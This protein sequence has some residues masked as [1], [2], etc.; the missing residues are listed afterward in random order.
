MDDYIKQL[1]ADNEKLREK[2][3][4]AQYTID[5]QTKELQELKHR[6]RFLIIADDEKFQKKTKELQELQELKVL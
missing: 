2:L 5:L 3:E 4:E 1:E 6:Y